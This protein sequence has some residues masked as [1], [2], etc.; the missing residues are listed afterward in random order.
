MR[1]WL[2]TLITFLVFMVTSTFI[3]DILPVCVNSGEMCDSMEQTVFDKTAQAPYRYRV[4]SPVLMRLAGSSSNPA[5][6]FSASLMI[7]VL[8]V[9]LIFTTTYKWLRVYLNEI[10]S[11]IGVCIVAFVLEFAF[12]RYGLAAS[13]IIEVA[14]LGLLL[15]TWKNFGVAVIL[16]VLASL[17]RETGVLLVAVYAVLSAGRWRNAAFLL[18]LW[19]VITA[20]LHVALGPAPHVLGVV[21]TLDENLD[22]LPQ[23]I[24]V[25]IF[26]L[27]L[28]IMTA[29]GYK[30]APSTLR[31]LV[32]VSVIY[33]LAAFGWGLWVEVGR[34]SLPAVILV[35]PMMLRHSGF[36]S[37]LSN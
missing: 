12:H 23:A 6:W 14:L 4:L 29:L 1:I 17:N 25:N 7:H 27:P 37:A 26:M 28:W 13:T 10:L 15:V 36:K 3:H 18:L 34:M 11:V 2:V 8:A 33:M 35:L 9:V 31:Q 5:A 32:W 24:M 20:G 16:V 19:A 22:E 30:T 21:G